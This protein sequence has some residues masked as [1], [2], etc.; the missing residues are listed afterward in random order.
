MR[1]GLSSSLLG[2]IML[3]ATAAMAADDDTLSESVKTE[4]AL[5]LRGAAEVQSKDNA[6]AIRDWKAAIAA[7]AFAELSAVEQHRLY[8][9]LG[10]ALNVE[11]SPEALAILK[12]ATQ[13]NL[14]DANDW[15]ERLSSAFLAKD[16]SD[17]VGCLTT[18]AQ[19]WP[20]SLSS[21]KDEVIIHLVGEARKIN[22]DTAANLLVA[23]HAVHWRPSD[24]FWDS[25]GLWYQ[26]SLALLERH[27]DANAALV[28]GEIRS[29]IYLVRMRSDQRFD[30]IVAHDPGHFDVAASLTAEIE[31]YRFL[32]AGS[33]R[34]LEGAAAYA[35]ILI[36]ANRTSDALDV[37]DKVIAQATAAP[38]S[39]A[40]FDDYDDQMRWIFN[41]RGRAL[42]I[43]GKAVESDDAFKS[44]AQF[45]EYGRPN[46]SQTLNRAAER[47]DFDKP[48]EAL[49]IVA[50]L[51]PDNL[52]DYGRMVLYKVEACAASQRGDDAA[53]ARDIAFLK[54][55][56]DTAPSNLLDALLCADD[57][58]GAAQAL[59]EQL[60]NPIDRG[61]AL[62]AMQDYIVPDHETP[63]DRKLRIR[64]SA[65]R[66]RPDVA[67]VIA[68]VGH[69]ASYPILA[70]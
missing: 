44:A 23:L 67:A 66:D 53:V 4:R 22:A 48:D 6:G 34:K 40:S 31:K 37:L 36:T 49:A 8:F 14:A 55:H 25:D 26:L 56:A 24:I 69:V 13:S 5:I 7:P 41:Q 32:A 10:F 70:N 57:T 45:A 52:S 42:F 38:G 16:Y 59:T 29:T 58:D 68:S 35:D 21:L 28:A 61:E 43:L 27:D 54:E 65:L 39:S 30:G 20:D 63:F 11:K 51:I 47:V 46:A 12:R 33:P 19:R 9:A 2:F 18:I 15:I 60:R 62:L 3:A 64:R 1:N 17:A 50:E